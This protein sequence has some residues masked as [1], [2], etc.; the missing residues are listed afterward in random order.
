MKIC[1]NNVKFTPFTTGHIY[2]H[3]FDSFWIYSIHVKGLINLSSG[4]FY[5]EIAAIANKYV[6]LWEDVTEL[7]C[8]KRV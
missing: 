6:A 3:S 7:Y 1:E 2:R 8:L 5:P 4:E